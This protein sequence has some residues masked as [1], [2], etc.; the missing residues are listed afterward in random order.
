MDNKEIR[1]MVFQRLIAQTIS[2]FMFLFLFDAFVD[3]NWV[4]L[5]L[6][7]KVIGNGFVGYWVVMFQLG[8]YEYVVKVIDRKE[9]EIE[10]ER[11]KLLEQQVS[12]NKMGYINN[13]QNSTNADKLQSLSEIKAK[14]EEVMNKQKEMLQQA[15]ENNNRAYSQTKNT[16]MNTISNNSQLSFIEN[17]KRKYITNDER[18]EYLNKLENMLKQY[19]VKFSTMNEL[20]NP[21]KD[22]IQNIQ[23]INNDIFRKMKTD[24]LKETNL[25]DN[26]N[27][28]YRILSKYNDYLYEKGGMYIKEYNVIRIGL[29]G[30]KN[31]NNELKLYDDILTNMPNVRFE[32]EG[33]SVETDNLVLSPFGIYA[34]EVKNLGSTG[35]YQLK[36][37][38]DG[39]W[40]K[41]FPDGRSEIMD[42]V[43]AQTYRHIGIKQKLINKELKVKG[44]NGEYIQLKPLIVIANDNVDIINESDVPI[45][46]ISNIY[47]HISQQPKSLDN[48][49]ISLVEQIVKENQLPPKSYEIEDMLVYIKDMYNYLNNNM[50]YYVEIYNYLK[51]LDKKL[52]DIKSM[53]KY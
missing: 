21:H 1:G 39:R 19:N 49:T 48:A 30:E 22:L 47:H 6:W 24:I 23:H 33:L 9:M 2:F 41:L 7:M 10:K 43:T 16:I 12:L 20:I 53:E 31:I 37:E 50:N 29:E 25:M 15:V 36:I 51:D 32:V 28:N 42:N 4:L 8:R 26:I 44:Y 3:I 52:V 17:T 18:M 38:K 13:T 5:P 11:Q 46:R 27:Y 14:Q 34:M 35:S 45:V 40:L